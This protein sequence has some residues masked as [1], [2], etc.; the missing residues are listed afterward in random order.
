[1]LT[2]DQWRRLKV[3][4]WDGSQTMKS[5]QRDS[6]GRNLPCLAIITGND[7]ICDLVKAGIDLNQEDKIG[8]TPLL[9]SVIWNPDSDPKRG[10]IS[11]GIS[12]TQLL[13][14]NGANINYQNKAGN[15][16]LM[17]SAENPRVFKFLI[18]RGADWTLENHE[19]ETV[20]DILQYR[21][22]MN[23][24]ES[25]ENLEFLQIWI[26]NHEKGLLQK[27]LP[28]SSPP[29]QPTLPRL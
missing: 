23:N 22:K 16:T 19:G 6:M 3:F 4:G 15:T 12:L 21:Q 5:G 28:E 13:L 14:D 8:Q 26:A 25:N 29:I 2:D 9:L 24:K 27:S 1:M 7:I 17:F 11:D 10:Q 20:L 18:E